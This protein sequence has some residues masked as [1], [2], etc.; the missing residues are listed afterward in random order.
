MQKRKSPHR[1]PTDRSGRGTRRA[2][3]A[4]PGRRRPSAALWAFG[5]VGARGRRACRRGAQPRAPAATRTTAPSRPPTAGRRLYAT[6]A[7]TTGE[8][9]R[10]QRLRHAQQPQH[11]RSARRPTDPDNCCQLTRS[12]T[13]PL[14]PRRFSDVSR[15]HFTI[16][17]TLFADFTKIIISYS[18]S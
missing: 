18:N 17:S 3:G 15:I 7:K 9:T 12:E 6:A 2:G 14:W 8:R 1:A 5:A 11:E 16:K 4:R 13:L 10:P